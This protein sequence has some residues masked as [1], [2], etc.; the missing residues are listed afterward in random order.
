MAG[1]KMVMKKILFGT[2]FIPLL[3]ILIDIQ[4]VYAAYPATGTGQECYSQVP[5]YITQNVKPNID[6]VLDVSGS[7]GQPAYMS[8]TRSDTGI[9]AGCSNTLDSSQFYD[10]TKNYYG[11]FKS[12]KYYR[13]NSTNDYFED[14]SSNCTSY[15]NR[16]GSTGDCL[17]GNLL[18]WIVTT[19]EDTMRKILTGGRVRAGSTTATTSVLESDGGNYTFTDTVL[20]CTFAVSA[21]NNAVS[22]G[23]TLPRKIAVSNQ[24][25]SYTCTIGTMNASN[26]NVLTPI[27]D[28]TG[29][30]QGLYNLADLEV[31]VFG[32][33]SADYRVGKGAS[34]ASYVDAIN[35]E[36]TYGA[37][38]TGTALAETMYFFQQSGNLTVSN[39]TVVLGKGSYLKDPYYDSD[40]AETPGSLPAPCR[41]SFALLISDGAW[42]NVWG[43][44]VP[45]APTTG[46]DP[47]QYAH[48]M[49]TTDIRPEL[50]DPDNQFVT[51]Y[52]VYAYG[53]GVYGRNSLIA[54][55]IFGGYEDKYGAHV[56]SGPTTAANGWPYPFTALPADSRTGSASTANT[57][58]YALNICN[59]NGTWHAECAEWDKD[60]TGLPYNYFEG[61]DGEALQA[62]INK[63]VYGILGRVASGAAASVLGNNDNNGA[64]M[65]QV[66]YFPERQF[67]DDTKASWTGELQALWFYVDPG[68]NSSKIT[69]REDTVQDKKLKLVQDKVASFDF[70]GTKVKVNLYADANADGAAD[71]ATPDTTVSTDEV[72][73]LWRAGL[74]LWSRPASGTGG[75]EVYTNDLGGTAANNLMDFST[76]NGGLLKPY[77]DVASNDIDADNVINYTLGA[78][79]ASDG[80]RD[81]KVAFRGANNDWVYQVWKL[82]DIINSTPKM[83]SGLQ[84]NTF[85]NSTPGGYDDDSYDKFI[86]SNDYK[87][88]GVAFVGANDGMLHAFKVGKIVKGSQGYVS[89][90][91]NADGN[92]ATELGNEL[93]AYIPK[94]V[95]PYLKHLG[96]PSY[97]H[98]FYV[99]STPTLIDASIGQSKF[100][101]ESTTIDC[102]P[103]ITGTKP[104]YTCAKVTNVDTSN[105]LLLDTSG[106][107][108]ALNSSVGTSW[109]TVLIGS[110]GWGGAT[111]DY[112]ASC[113]NCVKNPISGTGYSSYFALDVTN[114]ES[115]QFLWEFSHPNLGFSSVHPAVLR[116]KDP[117][118]N[119]SP[120]RNGRWYVVLASGPTGP[121]DKGSNQMKAYS[122]QSLAIFVLDLKTG[123]VV[124]TFSP[125]SS[126]I[127]SGVGHTQVSSMPSFAFGGT[128][129]DAT[130]DTDKGVNASNYSDDAVYLGYVRKDTTSG[131]PSLNKFVK[132]GVLRILTGDNADP[133]DWKV[134]TVI[135]GIGPV[136]SAV[137]KLQ[138]RYYR[139]LWLYFGTG[140]Y[141]Y[142]I[143]SAVDE[144]YSG[145]QEAIYGIK[146]P[147]YNPTAN[148]LDNVS[149]TDSVNAD[150][151]T[152]QTGSVSST[153]SVAGW[154][155]NL[156]QATG[157]FNAKR[158]ITNPVRS[159]AGALFFTSFKPSAGICS[160]G[161]ATSLWALK[162]DTGGAVS[163]L[164]G[165]ALI[166]LSNGAFAPIDLSD[167]FTLNG[168][169]ET[170]SRTGVTSRDEPPIISNANHFPSRKILHI[171]ER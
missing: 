72:K 102:D 108:S 79:L 67:G 123:T 16:K 113:T 170:D 69:I 4:R 12:G 133:A 107:P 71:S 17:S 10:S 160:Y 80:Y 89:E 127:M 15:T 25:S 50:T 152:D 19:R 42:P 86:H 23:N 156:E 124:R 121:I 35:S 13:Y 61:D 167:A 9:V 149:C 94:N 85:N 117:S 140:R 34:L 29:V 49:H 92:A 129:S 169:R 11:Y 165:Q 130:I 144:D 60:K 116:I 142:K 101:T 154:K 40:G 158:I 97:K 106:S 47:V 141:F 148:D 95:L 138:D 30:V 58:P 24:S 155:I 6:L 45:P 126:A 91:R 20:H 134:S 22:T 171:Q 137:T 119:N 143:G 164:R 147:C 82:G 32:E 36:L 93:W 112:G 26:T 103:C 159:T 43:S 132:G 51:T 168:G 14:N 39:K 111:R 99:D 76:S 48:Q 7:M 81:R 57:V 63:A 1:G 56:A 150:D 18:N 37:T 118:D 122:D 53:D 62:A 145:Q 84:L 157:I 114:P 166:Q 31:T 125:D 3:Y 55:A 28:V 120:Q 96:N 70:D 128:F 104:Y 2:L 109:R 38:P 83:L 161:G 64:T 88:R 46:Q 90:V 59:P 27:E 87:N 162:Y 73:A 105:N 151:L 135:D 44:G 5:P 68:L 54:T 115:P 74:S 136:T 52:T 131:S 110:M 65:L 146:E 66:Q 163:G 78:D 8:C 77:L 100:E 75:R 21:T 33:S 41:K 153:V 139:T 98:L